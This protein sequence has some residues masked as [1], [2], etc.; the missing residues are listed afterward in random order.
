MYHAYARDP[1]THDTAVVL[2]V[3]NLAVT[4][5]HCTIGVAAGPYGLQLSSRQF[6]TALKLYSI[7]KIQLKPADETC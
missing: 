5:T 6:D 2:C 1:G 7:V 4:C 3:S